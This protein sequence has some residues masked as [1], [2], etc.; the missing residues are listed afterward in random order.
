M[1][2]NED[3]QKCGLVWTKILK[4][5]EFSRAFAMQP[6]LPKLLHGHILAIKAGRATWRKRAK[7]LIFSKFWSTLLYDLIVQP[8]TRL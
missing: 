2:N 5:T 6:C 4:K 8:L 3:V 7:I 1:E